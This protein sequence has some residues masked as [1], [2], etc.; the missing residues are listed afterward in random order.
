MK[1]STDHTLSNRGGYDDVPDYYR[2]K[3]GKG[4]TIMCHA[5]LK[6]AA[7]KRSIIT[8]DY[9]GEHWHLD[10]LDPPLANPPAHGTDGRKLHDWMCPLHVDHE[11]RRVDTR[12]LNPPRLARKIHLRKPRNA[13]VVQTALSRG[14][15]NN[16]IIDVLQDEG[17]ASESEFYDEEMPDG[18]VIYRMPASGIK[19]DFIDKVKRY[20]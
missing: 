19:L 11:L 20:A 14:F 2:V 7:G 4:N 13:R 6:T 12:L 8:C 9:C 15:Q 3:D 18:S 16:G 1:K 17:D 5:C 10:C